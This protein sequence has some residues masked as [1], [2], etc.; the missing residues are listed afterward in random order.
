LDSGELSAEELAQIESLI[1]SKKK[2]A[3]K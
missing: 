1:K 2:A 3:R